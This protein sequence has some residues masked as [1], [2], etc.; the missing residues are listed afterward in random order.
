MI[1]KDR[2]L[3]EMAQRRSDEKSLVAPTTHVRLSYTD[4]L[5]IRNDNVVRVGSLV[6]VKRDP[7]GDYPDGVEA[8]D[9]DLVVPIADHHLD[10]LQETGGV[11]DWGIR[12]ID[13]ERQF[14]FVTGGGI[15]DDL[16]VDK[17]PDE[18]RREV[19]REWG[20]L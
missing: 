9:V 7:S 10:E 13:G 16:G 12:Y 6:F 17:T 5:A 8:D 15:A 20:K 14:L 19:E 4:M 11:V 2:S 3:S 18:V 1:M